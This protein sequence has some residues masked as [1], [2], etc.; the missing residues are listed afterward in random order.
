MNWPPNEVDEFAENLIEKQKLSGTAN[1]FASL[2]LPA[3][4]KMR[5]NELA[6]QTRQAMLEAAI[7][8]VKG[9]EAQLERKELQDPPTGKDLLST[10]RQKAVLRCDRNFSTETA[11]R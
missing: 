6:S 10:R 8:V 1:I 2:I 7:A 11:S 9:D 5:R 3:A 4:G